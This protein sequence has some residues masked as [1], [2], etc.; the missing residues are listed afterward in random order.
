MKAWIRPWSQISYQQRMNS[1]P[2]EILLR[3]LSKCIDCKMCVTACGNRHGQARMTMRGEVFGRYQLPAVC[4]HCDDPVC[5]QVCPYNAMQLE[6]GRT[7]VTPDCRGCRQCMEACPH[8]AIAMRQVDTEDNFFKNVLRRLASPEPILAP[9]ARIT[10][11]SERCVQCGICS[12]NCPVGVDVRS[13]AWQGRPVT[14]ERCVQ[15]G[16]CVDVCPR[17]VLSWNE[18]PDSK[19]LANKCDLCRGYGQSACV[20]ECPTGAMMRVTATEAIQLIPELEQKLATSS[21][22]QKM[23]LYDAPP[24]RQ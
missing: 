1:M 2:R 13:F 20:S 18:S 3:D 5:V 22:G 11:D 4:L 24:I 12:S 21:T 16:L 8:S 10:T 7:F 15:C 23:T 14:D 17:R 9:M 6:N 19:M